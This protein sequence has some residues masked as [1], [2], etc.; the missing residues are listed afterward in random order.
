MDTRTTTNKIRLTHWVKVIQ[1]RNDSGLSIKAYC[2]K[3]GIHE[4]SYYYWLKKLRESACAEITKYQEASNQTQRIF[5][6]VQL[7]ANQA[8]PLRSNIEENQICVE[9]NGVRIIAGSGYPIERL[10]ELVQAANS[11]RLVA[12]CY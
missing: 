4:S 9:I 2:K 1:E 10:T 7:P 12:Q 5:T 8:L 6:Q 11:V 3:T